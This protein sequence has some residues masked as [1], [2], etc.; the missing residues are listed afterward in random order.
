MALARSIP[1][2]RVYGWL[3]DHLHNNAHFPKY[4]GPSIRLLGGMIQYEFMH[5][6]IILF[7]S[8]GLLFPVNNNVKQD[9]FL[10]D[11][12]LRHCQAA[13]TAGR[14]L[15]YMQALFSRIGAYFKGSTNNF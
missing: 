14:V 15:L 12:M 9:C 3:A 7:T 4:L 1:V 8:R 10:S 2:R 5:L 13:Y 6:V 11:M